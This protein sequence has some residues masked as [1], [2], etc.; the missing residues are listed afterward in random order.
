M[1]DDE[2]FLITI[3]VG[4]DV[5][6]EDIETITTKVSKKYPDAEVDVRRGDQPVYSFLVG[7][8]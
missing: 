4:E 7:V 1:V 2:S 5:K 3:L 8:E 6:D